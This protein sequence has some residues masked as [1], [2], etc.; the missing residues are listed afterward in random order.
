M[1]FWGEFATGLAKIACKAIEEKLEYYD[2]Y[3]KLVR[4]VESKNPN[5]EE[6]LKSADIFLPLAVKL[7][8][9]TE[10]EE[11]IKDNARRV[12][13]VLFFMGVCFSGA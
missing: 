6:I 11:I 4:E 5:P 8:E 2:S 7:E 9:R 3:K 10:D 1:G 12:V 13:K